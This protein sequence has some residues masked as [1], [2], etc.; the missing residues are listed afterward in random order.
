[1]AK[2][3]REDDWRKGIQN[4]EPGDK[5]TTKSRTVTRSELE[6]FA[7][8]GGDYAAQFLSDKAAKENGWRTQLVPGLCAL[9]IGY[10]LLIQAGFIADVIA[11]MGTT[12]MQFLA[13]V[14]PEDSIRM[15]TVV[16]AKKQSK[17]GWICEYDWAILN[18]DDVAV[19]KG[20]NV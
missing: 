15:E 6:F 18:Q 5:F 3:Y 8:L 9:N 16:T 10:G 7:L 19:A 11:Y 14:Y 2:H 20:H 1:M 12:D 13:P 4:M 17:K